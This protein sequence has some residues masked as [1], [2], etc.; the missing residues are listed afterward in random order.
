M[1]ARL[2][3]AAKSISHPNVLN[4]TD[5]ALETMWQRFDLIR[6]RIRVARLAREYSRLAS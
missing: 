5:A 2:N 6:L 1:S 3:N 4:P